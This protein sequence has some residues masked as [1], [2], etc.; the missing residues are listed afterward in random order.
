MPAFTFKSTARVREMRDLL[1]RL[2][3]WDHLATAADGLYW[4][5]V[6]GQSLGDA[7]E[8]LEARHMQDDA[9]MSIECQGVN[10]TNRARRH[11]WTLLDRAQEAEKRSAHPEPQPTPVAVLH[12]RGVGDRQLADANVGARDL[13]LAACHR[14][15][16]SWFHLGDMVTNA[17]STNF[18]LGGP[19]GEKHRP[20]PCPF[21]PVAW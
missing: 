12:G 9:E 17:A 8:E 1:L 15:P 16:P 19:S 5:S 21:Q 13:D 6:I 4:K 20:N 14:W 7:D 11:I 2:L 18:H 10:W 3:Q